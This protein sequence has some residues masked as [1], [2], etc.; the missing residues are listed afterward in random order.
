MVT[1]AIASRL[2]G[3]EKYAALGSHL[4]EKVVLGCTAAIAA[5]SFQ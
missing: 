5:V 2:L 1:R 3:N 4:V